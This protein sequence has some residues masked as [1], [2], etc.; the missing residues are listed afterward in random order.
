LQRIATEKSPEA[1]RRG[2]GEMIAAIDPGSAWVRAA[3]CEV[4]P[5]GLVMV[6][7]GTVRSEGISRGH[8]GSIPAVAATVAH[9][10]REAEHSAGRDAHS[11]SVLLG[12]ETIRGLN[13]TGS[14]KIESETGRVAARDLDRAMRRAGSIGLPKNRAIVHLLPQRYLIDSVCYTDEPV[15]LAG[16]RLE[17]ETHVISSWQPGVENL[18]RAIRMAGYH[19]AHVVAAPLA[20]YLA[21]VNEYSDGTRVLIDIGGETTKLIGWDDG[22]I[23]FTKVIPVGGKDLSRAVA[24]KLGIDPGSAERIKCT[25]GAATPR[26]LE[27]AERTEAVSSPAVDGRRVVEITAQRLSELL[28]PSVKKLLVEVRA[29]LESEGDVKRFTG[30]ALLT[31]GGARL[32][33]IEQVASEMLWIPARRAEALSGDLAGPE[34][35][36]VAGLL[37]YA[38][39]RPRRRPA[40]AG[41]RGLAGVLA[42]GW[43]WLLASF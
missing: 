32:K 8:V 39:E 1:A 41:P 19:V 5:D 9:A 6:G 11:L 30:G 2:R 16:S 10:V 22:R 13:T 35:A 38:A 12:G 29:V 28:E 26:A 14:A 15:G 24:L 36:A 25:W 3:I 37:R 31:G 21:V 34:F 40:A 43:N 17:A 4:T 23:T 7:A 42:G 18:R 33:G 20:S 27:E